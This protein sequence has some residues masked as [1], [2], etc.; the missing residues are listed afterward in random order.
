MISN[1]LAGSNKFKTKIKLKVKK[2]LQ[3][4]CEINGI[5]P[6]FCL[7]LS[8]TYSEPNH[9]SK[10]KHFTKIVHSWIPLTIFA[11]TFVLEIWLGY[12]F[13]SDYPGFFSFVINRK[14][15][16]R[17]TGSKGSD[18][19]SSYTKAC[20]FEKLVLRISLLENVHWTIHISWSIFQICMKFVLPNPRVSHWYVCSYLVTNS[21]SLHLIFFVSHFSQEV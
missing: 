14:R 9:V 16:E 6:R 1:S 10:I 20:I 12:E 2:N 4:I 7:V 3:V 8:D 17:K 13:V 18:H 19:C 11:K 15:R 5:A 21:I